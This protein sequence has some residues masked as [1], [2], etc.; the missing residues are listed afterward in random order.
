MDVVNRIRG[1]SF[2]PTKEFAASKEDSIS[3][4]FRYF[5]PFLAV[6]GA[7][8]A[9]ALTAVVLILGLSEISKLAPLLG[10]GAFVGLIVVG[11]F[12]VLY[13]AVWL[14]IWVYLM[15]GRNGLRQT[16]KAITY[17]VTPCLILWWL[18]GPNI[19]IAPIWSLILVIYG[20]KGLHELSM[21]NSIFAI[22]LAVLVPLI[23]VGAVTAAVVLPMLL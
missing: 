12:A 11:V 7:I 5:V 13:I 17:G 3:D 9:I 2:H 16:L 19:L 18:P 23:V 4:A 10:A 15:G 1:F 20:L 14:H 22:V 21:K 6:I 8:I